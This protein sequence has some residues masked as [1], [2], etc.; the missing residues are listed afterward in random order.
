MRR[1]IRALTLTALGALVAGLTQVAVTAPAAQAA[2]A[3]DDYCGGQCNDIL[4]PG[5]NGNATLADIL[6]QQGRSAPA[7][8]TPTTS[9][10]STPT[11]PTATR[12]D[13]RPAD[14]LL[15][16]LLVRRAGRPGGEHHPAA[17]GRHDRARQGHRRPAHHR[18]HPLRHRVRRRLRRG[19]GP[20]VADG[21]VPPRRPR[22]ADRRSPA[23]RRP[24]A[25]W[26]RPSGG[27]AVHR[28]TTCRSRSTTSRASG[29]ARRAGA[30]GR[31]A[32]VAGIN[33]YITQAYNGRYFP[34]EYDLTGHIN[35]ITNAGSIDPFKLTDLV[36]IASVVGALFGAA[37]AARCSPRW[38]SW[39]PTPST[40]SPRATRCGS[41][42]RGRTT[43]RPSPPCTTASPS[44]TAG[45]GQPAGRRDAGPGL[46][47]AAAADLR[48]DRLGR[49]R[50][51]AAR[52]PTP[53]PR[54][55][56]ETARG[57]FDNG[58][59]PGDLLT[60]KHGMSN[61]LVVSGKYTRHR[62]PGRG[63]RPADR[64]L[65]PAAADAARNCRA[66]ASAPAA[67]PSPASACTCSSAAARTTRGAPRRRRRTSPT[68]TRCTL[69]DPTASRPTKDSNYYLYHGQC[70]ADGHL[71]RQ[72]LVEADHR[73]RHRGGLV[74][75]DRLPHQVRHGA[76]A[77]D[78]RRQTGG[79]HQLRSRYMHEVDSIIGFQEFNDPA[80]CTVRRRLPEGRGR[81]QLH[82]QLVLR[83]LHGHRLLQLGQQPG[84]APPNI[85]PN[86]PIWGDQ[87]YEWQGWNPD[88][89]VATYTPPSQHPKSIDQDYYVSWNNKQANDFARPATA[90]RLGA[91][92]QPAGRRVKQLV[93]SGRRS[94][95][96][97]WPRRW[98]TRRSP[99]C[100]A[101]TC[102][103]RCCR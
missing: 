69:C 44:R 88:G 30:A 71:E 49:V 19:A 36:A 2:A 100:A 59:L 15:Q 67:P 7:R 87:Q 12:P 62:Q 27:R 21:R 73:R 16:R 17:L 77:G 83:G 74:Q 23:A 84:R 51:A 58:V 102:C 26:S 57:I 54:P 5:E 94:P 31:Q 56:Q 18:H 75:A 97:R 78:G 13:Q 40:A 11:W 60:A 79:V 20:A 37:A 80:R 55:T 1:G 48:P 68:R 98:R 25:G 35:P 96:R 86:L 85:D 64:L 45:P 91:P 42:P 14:Q 95:G 24:T 66:R 92:R 39:P 9:S 82:V 46:G 38:S 93:S 70:I 47:D 72:E 89:N 6:A 28:G 81:R 3:P 22:R 43:P 101:R 8:R 63:V 76:V 41:L 32:Y 90:R 53:A 61:A 33:T 52:R 10:A 65:R 99:T 34:G 4:P 29:A 103:R 50:D